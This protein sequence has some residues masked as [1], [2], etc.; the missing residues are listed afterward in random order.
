MGPRGSSTA[1]WSTSECS[2]SLHKPVL[3]FVH[4]VLT[5]Q[6]E[7]A[8][9]LSVYSHDALVA[10]RLTH[11]SLTAVEELLSWGFVQFSSGLSASCVAVC[12]I[13]SCLFLPVSA[14]GLLISFLFSQHL[15]I[16]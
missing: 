2:W 10:C 8:L 7:L 11:M 12:G 4:Q 14:V 1:S 9:P 16:S 15:A 6:G 3:L 5:S 13:F